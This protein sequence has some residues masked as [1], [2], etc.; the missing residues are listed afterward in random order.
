MLGVYVR[1]LTEWNA[2]INLISRKD[3]GNIWFSHILH[4]IAPLFVVDIPAGVHILDLGSGGGLPGI[5]LAIVRGDLR[6]TLLDSIRK[7]TMV[8]E[9][10]IARLGMGNAGVL[11]GRAEELAA[12]KHLAHRFDI[13]AARAVAPL[14]DLVKW[15]K[16]FLKI[17]MREEQPGRAEIRAPQR[18][19]TLSCPA[20]MALKGGDLEGEI[21]RTRIRTGLSSLTVVDL[22]FDGSDE[23]GLED[24]KLIV[25]EYCSSL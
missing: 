16:P 18:R 21:S 15:S 14:Q 25:V 24:K 2:K 8:L 22:V 20:L 9:D 11:T 1:L 19:R 23:L 10:I 7:K 5:P 6:L 4:S 3:V 17:D 13:V 12:D